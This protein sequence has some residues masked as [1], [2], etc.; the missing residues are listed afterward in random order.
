MGKEF[1]SKQTYLEGC[2]NVTDKENF[3][4]FS[5]PDQVEKALLAI[6]EKMKAKKTIPLF[7]RTWQYAAS[8]LLLISGTLAYLLWNGPT[9]EYL[10]YVVDKPRLVKEFC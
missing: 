4:R 7:R 8:F 2:A 5:S 6:E 3:D 1:R 9:E 10:T